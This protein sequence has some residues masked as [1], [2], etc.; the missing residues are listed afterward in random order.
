MNYNS[1]IIDES[2]PKRRKKDVD[3]TDTGDDEGMEAIKAVRKSSRENR[4]KSS[5]KDPSSS[6]QDLFD[7]KPAGRPSTTQPPGTPKS[8]ARRH[9]ERRK[10]L[11]PESE[12]SDF[13]EDVVEVDDDD[14]EP[15]AVERFLAV[16][17]E[18]IS[19]WEKILRTVNT[20]EISFGSR[21]FQDEPTGS[22]D[23]PQERFLVKWKDLSFLHASWE[24]EDDL[25]SQTKNAK[26]Y[27]ATFYRKAVGGKLYTQDERQDGDYFDP[28][29]VHVDRILE[30]D[31]NGETFTAD[32]E[33]E[34]DHTSFG[35]V[36][37]KQHPDFDEGTGRQLLVKW[38]NLPY[39]EASYEF[40]RDL[41]LNEVEYKEQTKAFLKRNNKQ[42]KSERKE[43]LTKGETEYKRLYG[44]LGDK[45]KI[46]D[47]A[48]EAKAQEYQSLLQKRVYKNGG[49]LRDYQAE[50]IAWMVR[51]FVNKRSC[52]LADEM[53]L[54]KTLQTVSTIE[55]LLG[56]LNRGGPALIIVPLSTLQHWLR[57]FENWTDL[58]AILYYG[59][60]EDRKLIRSQ[61]FAFEAS[62]PRSVSFN[63]LYLK[64][65]RAKS[66]NYWMVDVVI[67]TP[68]I[69]VSD[70]ASELMQVGWEV[71]VVDEA[72]RLKNHTSK[73]G[74]VLRSNKFDFRHT[75]LLT[76]TPIQNNVEEFWTLLHFIDPEAYDDLD[77]FLERFGKI[78]TQETVN[79][80]H[81]EIR[82]YILRRLKEDVEKS[83][84]PKEETLIEVELTVAQKTYYR[85]LYEKNV[86]FLSKGKSGATRPKLNNLAMQ[87]RKV[88]NHLFLL[89]GVEDEFKN[90]HPNMEES[91]FLSKGSGKFVLLDKL[92]PRLKQEGHRVLM[93]SQF[94]IMLD[95]LEDYLR[96]NNMRSERID[97][98]ITGNK[99]Q[100]AIDR[101]QQG[102]GE[103]APFVML[104]STRAGGVGINLTAADTC[105]IFDSDF[106]PQNDLQAQARC[107]RIGQTKSV[108][109]YRLLTRKTYEIHMFHMSSRKMGLDQAVLSGVEGESTLSKK[110]M[111]NLL[112]HGAYDVFNEQN[113]EA[114]AASNAFIEQDIDSIMQRCATT[115]VHKNTGSEAASGGTFSKASFKAQKSDQ[116]ND[117][118]DIDDPD[119]WTKM[120]GNEAVEEVEDLTRQKR[121][122]KKVSS[123]ADTVTDRQLESMIRIDE[124]SDSESDDD[125]DDGAERLNWGGSRPHEWKQADARILVSALVAFGCDHAA[126]L[127]TGLSKDYPASEVERM[128]WTV[129]LLSLLESLDESVEQAKKRMLKEK[130][131]QQ[132]A[133]PSS[134]GGV[135]AGQKPAKLDKTEIEFATK[136]CFAKIMAEH[137]TWLQ[138]VFQNAVAFAKTNVPRE[139][140]TPTDGPGVAKL[141]FASK[142]WPALQSRG[143]KQ[144]TDLSSESTSETA[145][146]YQ[147]KKWTSEDDVVGAVSELHPD[148][149]GVAESL[150]KSTSQLEEVRARDL[151]LNVKSSSPAEIAGFVRRYG[152]AQMLEDRRR[153]NRLPFFGRKLLSS[154]L[155]CRKLKQHVQSHSTTEDLAQTLNAYQHLVRP[156]P[157]W[158][159]M[160]D[161]ILMQAVAKHG[162]IEQDSCARAIAEDKSVVWGAPF[163]GKTTSAPQHAARQDQIIATAQTVASVFNEKYAVLATLKDFDVGRLTKAY[164]LERSK[165]FGKDQ[166]RWHVNVAKMEEKVGSD[167]GSGDLPSK[168]D[169]MKRLKLLLTCKPQAVHGYVPLDQ[170]N[171]ANLFL[172]QLLSTFVRIS[173]SS[174]EC[175]WIMAS[176]CG[177]ARRLLRAGLVSEKVVQQLD[178][179]KSNCKKH[180]TSYKN[181]VR[182]ML[183]KPPQLPSRGGH[184]GM[185][186]SSTAPSKSLAGVKGPEAGTKVL[187]STTG[188]DAINLARKRLIRRDSGT[189]GQSLP[190]TGVLE[191]TDIET[192]I[193]AA[194]CEIGMPVWSDGWANTLADAESDM[195]SWQQFGLHLTG[196][197]NKALGKSAA[198][199]NRK[200]RRTEESNN[201][202]KENLVASFMI[203]KESHASKQQSVDQAKE[204]ARDPNSLAMKCTMLLS[205]FQSEM[206]DAAGSNVVNW[207][208][209]QILQWAR[210]LG[211]LD[212]EGNPIAATAVE[213]LD[214][215]TPQERSTVKIVSIFDGKGCLSAMDQVAVVTGVRSL[216]AY[217]D[218]YVTTLVAEASDTVWHS[219]PKDWQ[220]AQDDRTLLLRIKQFG[221]TEE[222]MKTSSSDT[223]PLRNKPYFLSVGDVQVRA[224]HLVRRMLRMCVLE[225]RKAGP[226]GGSAKKK[227]CIGPGVN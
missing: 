136:Q 130:Q 201:S 77:A 131:K 176:A 27:L 187:H 116:K 99:R 19:D 66:G 65:C 14:E 32:K 43:Y 146:A 102:K 156:H 118:V 22:K 160:H 10:S 188:V 35:M 3:L 222:M 214:D 150:S 221:M 80:L 69:V 13:E 193:I 71:L 157:Q 206:S 30:V 210:C 17:T 42:T 223:P 109:V 181:I 5:M 74:T 100:Q 90:K 91:E 123:Y 56:K 40:E 190:Q 194:S 18:K 86:K 53:G 219:K 52:I 139:T 64:Q 8:P 209:N 97:G 208:S 20:S 111:E 26:T 143:W 9:T 113:G 44:F 122:R 158:T 28:G 11:G 168:K 167:G 215:L 135:L 4:F 121:Q 191:L 79:E 70:D 151:S 120:I 36:M 61:E 94:K 154:T 23:L 63:Q 192:L 12:E 211:I 29:F 49:Q 73:L 162:W 46:S 34:Y 89:D 132:D 169:L 72:H 218:D 101:F 54:G 106:N 96:A 67:T 205:K 164:G 224:G 138:A 225:K 83:V 198:E 108:K 183:G 84:P 148:L 112:R 195:L 50:G 58:N 147:G 186:P 182:V 1:G 24:T 16:R 2:P 25:V 184:D 141:E 31:Y 185:F 51:N 41:I 85:A 161:A 114:E 202:Q 153:V 119:F 200:R 213:F 81:S 59:S 55:L 174:K 137:G 216:L 189:A 149:A 144:E 177:E 196:L 75:I 105:I 6:L 60:A 87:L 133:P 93:F 171:G 217:D 37:D 152:T 212:N 57:E 163:D 175:D 38:T 95:I 117:D 172:G 142:L 159:S 82:P 62:R 103:A 78:E 180:T 115:V 170:S 104:L 179:V 134:N 47:E 220:L 48:R 203:A 33:D 68:E 98:N 7:Q 166:L 140:E 124:G 207:L 173:I 21:W 92:L 145:Y 45:S 199:M 128:V 15:L 165:P 76:G 110:E 107:H 226:S 227:A 197:A 129:A 88:C 126:H 204:Y 127:I 39:S 178:D 155:L 125:D